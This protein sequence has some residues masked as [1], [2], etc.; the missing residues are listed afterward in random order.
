M[1]FIGYNEGKLD[2]ERLI[3]IVLFYGVVRLQL[4]IVPIDY[5]AIGLRLST[6]GSYLVNSLLIW[7]ERNLLFVL[8][9]VRYE[10]NDKIMWFLGFS[11]M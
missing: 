11:T 7:L 6:L 5:S 10:S 2:A 3:K 4:Y 1:S 8:Q 9:V